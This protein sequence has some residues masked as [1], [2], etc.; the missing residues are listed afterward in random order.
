MAIA[1]LVLLALV[2]GSVH[3]EDPSGDTGNYFKTEDAPDKPEGAPD[4]PADPKRIMEDESMFV[5]KVNP[6]KPLQ[7]TSNLTLPGNKAAPGD[8]DTVFDE[9]FLRIDVNNDRKID[10][11]EVRIVAVNSL[12]DKCIRSHTDRTKTVPVNTKLG[13]AVVCLVNVVHTPTLLSS[14]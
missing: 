7:F 1:V 10:L 11:S 8:V 5:A 14:F 6:F 3:S 4:M 13:V 9:H 2:F 12:F